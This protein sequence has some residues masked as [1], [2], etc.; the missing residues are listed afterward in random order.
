MDLHAS[1]VY[2]T[3]QPGEGDKFEPQQEIETNGNLL[4][5]L[6]IGCQDS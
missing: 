4:E 1:Y 2:R 5:A 3:F 6:T